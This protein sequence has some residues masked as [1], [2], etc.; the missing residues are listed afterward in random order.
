MKLSA[1]VAAA[2]AAVALAKPAFTNSEFAVEEGKPI[3]LGWTGASGP[4]TLELVTGPDPQHLTT[5]KIITSAAAGTSF[6]YTPTGIPSGNYAF[7]ITDSTNDPNYSVLFPYTGTGPTSTPVSSTST[8]TSTRS[9]SASSTSDASS[10]VTSAPSSST[11][12]STSVRTSTTA[13]S[14]TRS[15]PSATPTNNNEGQRFSSPLAMVLITVAALVF[16][17]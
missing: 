17:N 12:T 11:S 5:Y 10:S 8:G 3:T 4:V 1:I 6:T 16:F 2:F 14:T 13:A 15:A 9:S 7:R